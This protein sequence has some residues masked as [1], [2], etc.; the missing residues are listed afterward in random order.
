LLQECNEEVNFEITRCC[1]FLLKKKTVKRLA[2]CHAFDQSPPGRRPNGKYPVNTS[3]HSDLWKNISLQCYLVAT[4]IHKNS[5]HIR[6]VCVYI[7]I[8]IYRVSQE[9]CAKLRESVPYVKLYRYNPKHLY[10][11]LNG[12]GDNGQR[13]VWSS[14]GSTYCTC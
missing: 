12:Y 4:V 3:Q 1:H 14:C 8:Y 10:P 9:G 5:L 13:K 7:Y 11:K 6:C 2:E